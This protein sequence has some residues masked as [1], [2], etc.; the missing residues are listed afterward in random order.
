MFS[1]INVCRD[2]TGGT[3]IIT[4]RVEILGGGDKRRYIQ[5][6]INNYVAR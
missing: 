6:V 1:V 2:N 5:E 4:Q 3:E